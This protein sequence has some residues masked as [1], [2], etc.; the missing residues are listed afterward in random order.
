[1]RGRRGTTSRSSP[2]RSRPCCEE[3]A[4]INR[5]L[6]V[7]AE[8]RT[9][10]RLAL[11]T[12][13]VMGATLAS[14]ILGFVRE[15]VYARFYGTTWELDAFLAASVVPVILF[16]VFSGA[17]VS[18]LV[19]L[20]S[21]YI[22]TEREDEAWRLASSVIVGLI[23]VLG[24]CAALGALL[25]P[26]Y[27]PSIVRFTPSH[28]HTAVIM[29]RW[30]MPTIVATSVAGVIGSLLNAYHRFGAAALQGFVANLCIIAFVW[31]AQPRYGG[32]ALVFGARAGASGSLRVLMPTFPALR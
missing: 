22:S 18:A 10:R 9:P 16:G 1:M 27:V 28:V 19:P 12:M 23:V 32:Q 31:F 15:V 2:R 24:G 13:V 17:L 25:A 8:G 21:D 26:W 6:T 29:T 4:R 14:T 11:S 30:L 3:S 7:V 20:F 5:R